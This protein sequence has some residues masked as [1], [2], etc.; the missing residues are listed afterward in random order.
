MPVPLVPAILGAYA[1]TSGTLLAFP[2]LLHRRL[3]GRRMRHGS[4]RGGAGEATEN[5]LPAFRNAVKCGSELLELDVHLTADQQVVVAHDGELS[6]MCGVA[7]SI[8]RTPY[9][10]LPRYLPAAEL[11]L[12][13]PFHGPSVTL[14]DEA[15]EFPEAERRQPAEDVRRI[16]LLACVSLRGDTCHHAATCHHVLSPTLIV[17]SA[18][19]GCESSIADL[20]CCVL[21]LAGGRISQGDICRVSGHVCQHRSQGRGSGR[22]APRQGAGASRRAH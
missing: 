16:P 3:G 10:E 4:H 1:V 18:D 11:Q 20:A 5:T 8:A 14:A 2:Q 15:G 7:R 6:R 9:A 13:P 19:R 12:P 21:R 22:R 17:L